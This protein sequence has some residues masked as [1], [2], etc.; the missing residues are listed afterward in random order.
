[1]RQKDDVLEQ[2]RTRSKLIFR[3]LKHKEKVVKSDDFITKAMI[4]SETVNRSY[5][6]D[7]V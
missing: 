5:A 6:P 4:A 2:L 7:A 1:L 3:I